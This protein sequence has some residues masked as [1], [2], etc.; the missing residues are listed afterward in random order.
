MRM[1]RTAPPPPSPSNH[2]RSPS[3][4][5]IG[6]LGLGFRVIP[7]GEPPLLRK[8][9]IPTTPPSVFTHISNPHLGNT[10]S[11]P[12]SGPFSIASGVLNTSTPT[13]TSLPSPVVSSINVTTGPCPV[14]NG[15]NGEAY[16]VRKKKPD[17]HDSWYLIPT[18]EWISQVNRI[19][20]FSILFLF[21]EMSG[22][23][24]LWSGQCGWDFFSTRWRDLDFEWTDRRW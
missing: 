4:S 22:S 16:R 20:G 13:P 5:L 11:N 24:R 12:I 19:H 1:K 10:P 18:L 15:T 14:P 21:L 2:T 3:D 9:S 17:D 23:V 7:P 8:T 6:K